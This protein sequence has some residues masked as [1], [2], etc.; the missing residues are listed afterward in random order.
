MCHRAQCMWKPEGSFGEPAVLCFDHSGPRDGTQVFGFGGKRLYPLSRLAGLPGESTLT[1]AP[2]FSS[3]CFQ[4]PLPPCFCHRPVFPSPSSCHHW[5]NFVLEMPHVLRCHDSC[6][7]Q[8]CILSAWTS[9]EVMMSLA[10]QT[11]LR[12][13]GAQALPTTD[14]QSVHL[15]RNL[16]SMTYVLI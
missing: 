6:P 1:P 3:H 2:V 15:K 13:I 10:E 4:Q 12:D 14:S 11:V 8:I 7:L 5:S 9:Q 16:K